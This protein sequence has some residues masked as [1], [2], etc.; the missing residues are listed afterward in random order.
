MTGLA[1]KV[2]HTMACATRHQ[3]VKNGRIFAWLTPDMPGPERA[4]AWH[5]RGGGGDRDAASSAL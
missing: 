1:V 4:A 2:K 5:L 3:D